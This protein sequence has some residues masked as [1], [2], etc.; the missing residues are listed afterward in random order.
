MKNK[1]YSWL[2]QNGVD[3]ISLLPALVALFTTN[4]K[5]LLDKLVTID[6]MDN[7]LWAISRSILSIIGKF[8]IALVI[9]I[10]VKIIIVHLL[11]LF[12]EKTV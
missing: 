12:N 6:Q 11:K 9:F 3:V 2:K 5:S 1:L 4:V 10:I 8:A 7:T